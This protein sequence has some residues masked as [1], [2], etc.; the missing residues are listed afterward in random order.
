MSQGFRFLRQ[1][2]PADPAQTFR[3]LGERYVEQWKSVGVHAVF[4][5]TPDLDHFRAAPKKIQLA[6]ISYLEFNIAVAAEILQ[7]GESLKN[8]KIFLWRALKKLDFIPP[9][10]MM[11]YIED[12][13]I[14]EVYLTDE[15]QVFR[16]WKF[17]ETV[18]H[19]IEDI[20]CLPWYRLGTRGWKPLLLMFR[21]VVPF[22]MGLI[23]NITAWN[24][25]LH[26]VEEINS[27]EKVKF[28]ILLKYF[29]PLKQ[30]GKIV[31]T[32]STNQ[33]TVLSRATERK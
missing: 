15:I 31:A 13:D 22:K 5:S 24:V 23:Q 17:L 21:L 3:A 2:F 11:Q 30:R 27:L 18:S 10:D 4:S 28:T 8:T 12:E 25:P 33:S 29:I 7:D 6:A 26:L 1:E 19:T 32:I 14:I 16:N 20:L 9:S